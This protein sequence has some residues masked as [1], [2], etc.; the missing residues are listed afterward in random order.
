MAPGLIRDKVADR[1]TTLNPPARVGPLSGQELREQ[2]G[3][4]LLKEAHGLYKEWKKED[5]EG[6]LRK[7][8]DTLEIGR[9]PGNHPGRAQTARI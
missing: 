2:I 1:L 9:Y 3:R 7:S 6:I 4:T 8:A 5:S